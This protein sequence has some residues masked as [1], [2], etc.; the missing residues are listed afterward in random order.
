MMPAPPEL[1][2]QQDAPVSLTALVAILLGLIAAAVLA[3]CLPTWAAIGI[4]LVAVFSV[5]LGGGALLAK[6]LGGCALLA[7]AFWLCRRQLRRRGYALPAAAPWRIVS[8]A[9]PKQP[10]ARTERRAA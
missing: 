10:K 6:A 7:A 3:L 1:S 8:E 4:T 2:F 9:K 5:A